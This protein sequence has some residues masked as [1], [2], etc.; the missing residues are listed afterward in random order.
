VSPK[1]RKRNEDESFAWIIITKLYETWKSVVKNGGVD[2]APV[3][4]NVGK[5]I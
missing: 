1:N 3:E 5:D 2:R 4:M